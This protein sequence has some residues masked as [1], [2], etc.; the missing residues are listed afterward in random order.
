MQEPESKVRS[1]YRLWSCPDPEATEDEVTAFVAAWVRATKPHRVAEIGTY[2]G[3]TAEAIGRA[4]REN[5]RGWLHT[6]EFEY[7]RVS[8]ARMRCE[9][10][11]VTVHDGDG[12]LDLPASARGWSYDLVFIDG[13]LDNRQ[14]SWFAWRDRIA[15]MGVAMFHDSVKYA[16]VRDF[17]NTIPLPKVHIVSPRGLTIVQIP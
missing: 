4:L 12:N 6:F 7:R 8:Q 2:L 13:H 14:R 5:G 3:H 16:N 15:P 1:D 9:G 11:P 17:I 10:L